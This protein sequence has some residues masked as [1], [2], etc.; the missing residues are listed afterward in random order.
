MAQLCMDSMNV[1]PR[2][3]RTT[4]CLAEVGSDRLSERQVQLYKH[5]QSEYWHGSRRWVCVCVTV[6]WCALACLLARARACVCTR[7]RAQICIR[8]G[9]VGDLCELESVYASVCQYFCLSDTS[10]LPPLPL[11]LSLPPETECIQ[12]QKQKQTKQNK[13]K[14]KNPNPISIDYN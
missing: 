13:T 2:R 7:A 8:N 4:A 6:L 5:I 3:R 10:P 12:K 14:Q 9:Y 11:H 1:S